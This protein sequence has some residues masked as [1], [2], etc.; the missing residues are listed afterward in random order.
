MRT[1]FVSI[2]FGV[3]LRAD[4]G[5]LD[6]D[7]LFAEVIRPAVEEM[8][9]ECRR[10]DE[11]LPG[12]I[13]HKTLFNAVISSDLVIADISTDNANVFY[14]L[15]IRHAL[16]RGWTIVILAGER[17]PGNISYTQALR[18]HPD[19]TGR[20]TENAA[21]ELREALQA[22][23]RQSQQS[24]I[25][26]SPIYEF[27]PELEVILPP[28]LETSPRPR[29]PRP[30]NKL[31]SFVQSVVE[32]AAQVKGELEKSEAEVRSSADADPAQYLLLMRR[33]RDLSD[34]DRV[35]ALA[36][37]A[38][39]SV[40]PSPEIRQMLA[41]ALNRRSLPGDQERAITLME[42]QIHETGGDSETFGILGRIYKD[43]YDQARKQGDD[44]GAAAN[45]ERSLH[46]YR[47]GF[48]KNPRDYYPGINVINILLQQGDDAAKA[49]LEKIVPRVQAAVM[50]K[51]DT[52]RPDFWDL[53]TDLQLAAVAR[54]WSRA[55]RTAR[56]A[57]AQAPAEWMIETTLRDMRA[58][59]KTFA[60][61]HDRSQ[62]EGILELLRTRE[63]QAEEDYD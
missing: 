18:Y 19:E 51:L 36:D 7:F 13:W 56:L 29:R 47:E 55:K 42:Q 58:V 10:L 60:D 41:L 63:A 33:Y 49:E 22:S 59:G 54:D 11:Y 44:A 53:A 61:L 31:R 57:M 6:F 34:W 52:E 21:A 25:G 3:K 62:L 15:G 35:I 48:E 23:I 8:G 46:Y 20:L 26:D 1:C 30:A 4:G 38:P 16:R 45:L 12:A 37:D 24:P 17:L 40:V 50:E 2:P 43:R 32:S 27:F 39:Q 9:I 14:E 5:P 28:E